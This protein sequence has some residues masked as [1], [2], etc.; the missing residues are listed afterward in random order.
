[1]EENTTNCIPT[2]CAHASNEWERIRA[3]WTKEMAMDPA[4]ETV[5]PA[6]ESPGN[7]FGPRERSV[8]DTICDPDAETAWGLSWRDMKA[9]CS[10]SQLPN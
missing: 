8:S 1:M 9:A 6:A 5:V 7:P 4:G 3:T 10:P 2:P